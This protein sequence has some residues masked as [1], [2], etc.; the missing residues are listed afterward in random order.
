MCRLSVRDCRAIRARPQPLV[1]RAPA[2]AQ[3]PARS[4]RAPRARPQPL[5]RRAPARVRIL[6]ASPCSPGTSSAL[7]SAS[8]GARAFCARLRPPWS[9]P[10][11][12]SVSCCSAVSLCRREVAQWLLSS[13]LESSGLITSCAAYPR[14]PASPVSSYHRTACPRADYLQDVFC[15][16]PQLINT[17][18][19]MTK[20]GPGNN[21]RRDVLSRHTGSRVKD[22]SERDLSVSEAWQDKPPSQKSWPTPKHVQTSA[23]AHVDYV[24]KA[25][26]YDTC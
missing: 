10:Q 11:A 3:S 17:D 15:C 26:I 5:V 6:R 20:N 13:V 19:L 1:R 21:F 24:S 14:D 18:T 7:G 22:K 2:G 9:R 25:Y 12:Q 16:D 8:P 23:K 4:R